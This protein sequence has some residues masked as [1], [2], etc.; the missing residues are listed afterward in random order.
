MALPNK[1]QLGLASGHREL[2]GAWDQVSA[3]PHRAGRL[4]FHRWDFISSG[5]ALS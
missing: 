5:S 2:A 4:E 1:A 3:S